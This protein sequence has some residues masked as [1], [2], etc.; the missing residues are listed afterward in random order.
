MFKWNTIWTEAHLPG[1]EPLG[2]L[3]SLIRAITLLNYTKP[4]M[5]EWGSEGEAPRSVPGKPVLSRKSFL[6]C[7]SS[8][9]FVSSLCSLWLSSFLSLDLQRI[10]IN[11]QLLIFGSLHTRKSPFLQR[12]NISLHA[13]VIDNCHLCKLVTIITWVNDS[14]VESLLITFCSRGN[15]STVFTDLDNDETG[16]GVKCKQSNSKRSQLCSSVDSSYSILFQK[17]LYFQ[18][19]KHS[20]FSFAKDTWVVYRSMSALS[21]SGSC[22]G[23]PTTSASFINRY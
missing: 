16:V 10:N 22:L 9:T 23:E 5:H 3:Q 18:K 14:K 6:L 12:W 7:I 8:I 21:F 2:M 1:A 17:W 20:Y 4:Q 13:G 15:K 19:T 11:Y